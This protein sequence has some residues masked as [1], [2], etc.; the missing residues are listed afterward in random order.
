VSVIGK[1]TVR[2]YQPGSDVRVFGVFGPID[3]NASV[4]SIKELAT[5]ENTEITGIF[6]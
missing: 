1:W 5:A 4:E 6:R 3:C 2:C